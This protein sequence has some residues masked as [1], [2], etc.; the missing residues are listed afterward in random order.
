MARRARIGNCILDDMCEALLIE[1]GCSCG[2]CC[3]LRWLI[4]AFHAVC[5][6]GNVVVDV[7]MG[8][9]SV[10]GFM[11]LPNR[12]S[13]SLWFICVCVEID[14]KLEIGTVASSS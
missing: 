2:V 5:L 8:G 1:Y 10:S 13:M 4:I 7:V 14:D 11:V 9:A 6:V 12:G 3:R